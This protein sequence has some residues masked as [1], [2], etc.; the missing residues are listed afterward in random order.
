MRGVV[1]VLIQAVLSL[2]AVALVLPAILYA[3]PAASEPRYGLSVAAGLLLALF[4]VFRLVW[5]RPRRE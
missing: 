3:W 5:P 1:L 4:I 2:L